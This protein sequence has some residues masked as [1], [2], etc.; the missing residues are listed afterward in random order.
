MKFSVRDLVAGQRRMPI[1]ARIDAGAFGTQQALVFASDVVVDLEAQGIGHVVHVR[2]HVDTALEHDCARCGCRFSS[3]MHVPI[4]ERLSIGV[5]D[6]D[7]LVVS[8]DDVDVL[9]LVCE[10]LA[11][12]VPLAV[13]CHDQCL[14]LC[15][16]CGV[17]RNVVDCACTP[18]GDVRWSALRGLM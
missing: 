6:D 16:Q 15:P 17:D 11:V 13:V 10:Q 5:G 18:V 12:H 2:G 9:P 14:G 4:S 8:E 3:R 1:V 7:V